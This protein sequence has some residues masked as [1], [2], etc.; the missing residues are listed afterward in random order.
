MTCGMTVAPRMPAAR[1]I[2]ALP[3]RCGTKVDAATDPQDAL[4]RNTSSPNAMTITPTRLL[5]GASRR[6]GAARGAAAQVGREVA[7]GE[8]SDGAEDRGA[9]EGPP[10]PYAP[11]LAVQRSLGGFED[12]KFARQ[13][14]L[15]A[16]HHGLADDRL[17]DL[18]H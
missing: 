10:G 12:P 16:D 7:R 13:G 15:H 3:S 2:E 11:P 14:A 8:V 18:G 1:R 5:S 9:E 6:H 17:D 4:L